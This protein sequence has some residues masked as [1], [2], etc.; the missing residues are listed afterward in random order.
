MR[1]QKAFS[2]GKL[3]HFVAGR[4]HY[5][6][7]TR[8]L[9]AE[10][11]SLMCTGGNP[12]PLKRLL[13][14]QA[15]RSSLRR[16]DGSHQRVIGADVFDKERKNQSSLLTLFLCGDVMTGRGID[17]ILPSPID[18]TLHEPSVTHA[19]EYVELAENANGPIPRRAPF[20]YIWGNAPREWA[21]IRPDVKLINLETAITRSNDYDRAKCI[22]YRM[23][24]ANVGCLTAAG[25]DG[26]MLANNHVLDWGRAGLEETLDVLAR[27][28]I[29]TAGAGR[30]FAAAAS[31]A[32]FRLPGRGRLLVYACGCDSAGVPHEWSAS[33]RQP[34]VWRIDEC[35]RQSVEQ[36]ASIVSRQKQPDDVAVLS[37]H[38]GDNWGYH[39]PSEQR[40]F[41]H[42]VIES[43]GI[44]LV[45]GHSSHHVKGIEVYRQRLILYGC[46]D[47]LTDYE[48]ISGYEAYRGDLGLMYFVTLNA[49][50]GELFN[51]E[52]TST[53]VRRFQIARPSASDAAWLLGT[54]DRECRR[55]GTSVESTQSGRFVLS[56]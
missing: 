27:A 3:R 47:F 43:A 42:Q 54:L 32:A 49:A 38:W 39:I 17:Q 45:Y 48:G 9:L 16:F 5:F 35:S 11:G 8:N 56:W 34:G 52:M 51:L 19:A 15:D 31:P 18:G 2:Y 33:E 4:F 28:S 12:Q 55:L 25:I 40:H 1:I 37:I 10:S 13:N 30:D 20:D 46:G 41:A 14:D 7:G 26:C 23:H 6:P 24:P 44:D 22:H 36:I 50:S 29:S 21:R 53:Q